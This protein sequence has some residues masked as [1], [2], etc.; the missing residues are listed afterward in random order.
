MLVV[1]GWHQELATFIDHVIGGMAEVAI[2]G[3][4]VVGEDN[5]AMDK[6]FIITWFKF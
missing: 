6:Y 4:V 1:I 2:F 3:L 5:D